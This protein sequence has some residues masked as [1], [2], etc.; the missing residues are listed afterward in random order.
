MGV[1]IT[2]RISAHPAGAANR[3]LYVGAV[4]V[5]SARGKLVEMGCF[6]M[7]MPRAAEAIP[8]QLVIHDEQN[9]SGQCVAHKQ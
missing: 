7:R 6:Q 8:A 4:K 1:D 3:G 9:T 5:H 2:P